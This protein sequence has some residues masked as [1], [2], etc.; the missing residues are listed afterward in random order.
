MEYQRPTTNHCKKKKRKDNIASC[1]TTFYKTDENIE[2]T[3]LHIFHEPHSHGFNI[4]SKATF[5]G[6]AD[7]S[8]GE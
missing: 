8:F 7:D 2:N 6:E 3:A 1:G 5:V 4:K